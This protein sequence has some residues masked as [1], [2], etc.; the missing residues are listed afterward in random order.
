MTPKPRHV[1]WELTL[2]CDLA[3]RH[4]GSRAAH[5]RPDELD[6][7]A[8]LEVIESFVRIGV[9]EVSLIGGEA[10]LHDGWLTIIETLVAK[11]M[12]VGMTTGGRGFDRARARAAHDAGLRAVSVSIDGD[13]ESHDR[14][15][16]FRGAHRAAV[17]ALEAAREVGMQRSVITQ[18][19]RLSAP[20]LEDALDVAIR[21]GA[22]AWKFM[23]TVPMGRAAD[24]PDVL[25]QPYDLLTLQPALAKAVARCEANGVAAW[26]GNNIGYFGPYE[27]TL[28]ARFPGKHRGPCAAG[29]TVLGIEAQGGV[30][31][32]PSLPSGRWIG[33]NVRDDSLESIVGRA[34]ALRHLRD[35]TLD[36]LG[37]FCRSCYYA[38][39]CMGGCAWTAEA[40]TGTPGNNPYCHHRALELESRG[41]R[42]RL[43]PRSPAPGEPFDLA[44][45]ELVVEPTP[46]F[47]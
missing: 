21:L 9:S 33:G 41:L 5:A 11:G 29:N 30:K 25:L 37:G 24:E 20:G 38:A 36:D 8:C 13:E 12:D 26:P 14:L 32:C 46:R 4:C 31:G 39:A 45:F 3:C 10:Y 44:R 35:R 7:S 23:L 2:A 6:L 15:R 47:T 34:P 18:L 17:A 43:V 28:R 16:G 22:A 19:N 1:V 40:A 42:E 27:A